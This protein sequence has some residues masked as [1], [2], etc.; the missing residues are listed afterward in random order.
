MFNFFPSRRTT[1]LA[2]LLALS[3]TAT[4]A[5]LATSAWAAERAPGVKS[6]VLVHGAFADGGIWSDVIRLLQARGY[7]VTAFRIP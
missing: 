3:F 2:R 5:L 6:I 7:H 1:V 4:T